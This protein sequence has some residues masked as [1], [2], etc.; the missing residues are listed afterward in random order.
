MASRLGNRGYHCSTTFKS[1]LLLSA[2]VSLA[3]CERWPF[4]QIVD[5]VF[6]AGPYPTLPLLGNP[7][8][9]DQILKLA[10][11]TLDAYDYPTY[12]NESLEQGISW[13]AGKAEVLNLRGTFKYVAYYVPL[14]HK[15]DLMSLH[16]QILDWRHRRSQGR[17]L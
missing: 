5:Y 15:S 10:L 13:S 12:I 16:H 2:Y 9:G 6:F 11:D 3:H 8:Q 7:S 4:L 14:I 1:T 17:P